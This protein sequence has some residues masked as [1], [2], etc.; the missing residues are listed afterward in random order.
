MGDHDD[1]RISD[2]LAH[3]EDLIAANGWAIQG[4]F[5]EP[6]DHGPA[7]AYTVGLSGPQ[8]GHPELIVVGLDPRSAQ[9]ILNNLGER[10]RSG[11]RLHA[12]QQIVDLLRGGYQV[13]LVTVDDASDDRAPLSVANLLY[14][15][16]RSVEALQVV[17]PDRNHQFPWDPEFA[18]GSQPL[19]GQRTPR[20]A[21]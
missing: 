10:V 13:E 5:S 14:G 6:D 7:F 1:A 4:V 8:F 3:V 17:L 20:T 15:N 11:R 9:I 16:G 19:L 21:P 2:Y 12:G 18:D